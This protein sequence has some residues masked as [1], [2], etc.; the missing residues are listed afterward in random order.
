MADSV[1]IRGAQWVV[2]KALSPLSDGLVEAWAA[3]SALGPNI[4]AAKME[5]LYAQA[6]LNNARGR[7]IHNPA[8]TELLQKLRGLAYDAD[9][10]LD[11][12]DY[13]RIQ[14]ELEG[15]FETVD[16]GCFHDLVRDAHHTT[17]AAAKQLEC[18]SCCF[19]ASSKPK[20]GGGKQVLCGAWPGCVTDEEESCRCMRQ[21][22]NRAR[23]TVCSIGKRLLC[24]SVLPDDDDGSQHFN[25]PRDG[26]QSICGVC[27]CTC[28]A[29]WKKGPKTPKLDFDRV[30]ASRRMKHIAEQLQLIC[31][32]VSTI[33]D[34]ELLGSAIA[35]L[36]FIGSR[37]G[38]GGDTTTSRSTTT[39]KSIEPKLYGRD[40]EKN[41]I[42]ENITKGVHYHQDLSV[43]PIVGPGGIGKTTLT[44]YIY[45]SKEVQDHFQI[46]VWACVSLDFNVYRLSKEILNSIP[47]VEDEKG[48]SQIQSLDQLQKFIEKR[49]KQKRVLVVLDDIWK[50]SDEEWKRLLIPFT[51]CQVN[52]NIILVTT[53][54]FD[55]AEKVKT[56]NCKVTQLDGLNPTEFW[57]FFMACVFGHGESNQ[58]PKE[59]ELNS[60]GHQIVKKLK[61]SPL[62]A[63]TVGRLLR[64]NPTP[65]Y[66]TRV[67][68]S[69]EWDLQTSDYDIMPA[70]KLSYDYL[71]FHLQQCFS[72]C[73]LFPEDYK[74]SNEELIRFW[75][76]LD[77]L[78]PD[79]PS[80]RIEDIGHNYLNQLV[81]YE[82]FKKEIDEEHTY[83]AMHDLL[84][85]L[86]L[87]VS[88]Q[89][90][91]HID[92]S[93]GTPIEIPP[94]VYHLSIILSL[95]NCEE[96]TIEGSFK[97]KLAEMGSRLKTENLHTL[98]IFGQYDESFITIF[99][100]MFKDAKSLRVVHLSTMLHPVESILYSFPKL[101]HLR[102]IKLESNYM[103]GSHLPQSLSRFYHLRVLDIEQWHGA[104]SLP[105]D[106]TNLSKLRHFLV[107]YDDVH[108]NISNVGKFR[109]L[110]QLRLFKVKS[111]SDG[112]KLRELG[113]LAELGG[114]LSIC[115]LED[116][117][118]NIAHE[119]KLSYKKH[120]QKLSLNWMD[121]NR[122]TD[123][124]NQVLEILRPH[125]N[126]S[127]LQIKNGGSTCPTWLGTSL[128]IKGL[129]ALR[130]DGVHWK[131]LPPLGE[132]W[133]MD[134]SGH[135]YFG[136]TKVQNFRNLKKLK[137]IGLPN[138]RR[139]VA[140][141]V[142]PMFFLVVEELIVENC[143]ELIELPFSYYTQ[144]PSQGDEKITWFPNLRMTRI[145]DCPE[146]VSLPPVPFTQTLCNVDIA[147][148]GKS[149]NRLYY[150]SKSSELTIRGIKDLNGLNDKLLAFHSLTQ[151]QELEIKD[152]P[153]LA[154]SHLPML[155][156]LKKLKLYRSSIVV[157]L[158]ES[159]SDDEWQLPV[160]HLCIQDC[161]ASGKVLTQ[162]LSHLPML[163]ELHLWCC[164]NITRMCIAAEQ[165]QTN[166]QE[167][168]QVI[169]SESNQQQQV[170]EEG[171][172]VPSMDHQPQVAEDR[173]DEDGMLLLPSHLCNS[174]RELS[175]ERCTELL[176]DVARSAL[177]TSHS[178]EAG[179]W[180]LQPL[181]S[182]QRLEISG[183]PKLFSAYEAL[184][185]LFPSSLQYLQI[186]GRVEGVQT[187]DFSNLNF[188]TRL[189]ISGCGEDLRCEGV[190]PLLT[191]GQLSK[192]NVNGTPR[193]FAGLDSI[194]KGLQD[195]QEQQ[196]PLLQR[197]S[198]LQELVTKDFTGVLVKP[199]CR[200]LSS[201]L[202]SLYLH[203]NNEVEHFTKEQE[204][205]LQLL[206]SLQH[207]VFWCCEKLQR[208]PAGLRRLESLKT[209]QIERC[210]S[211]R[212]LPTG[213]LPGSLQELDVR[214]CG[215]E[216]L[217]QR[218][219][220]LIGTTSN[221]KLQWCCYVN[222]SWPLNT[223]VLAVYF[224]SSLLDISGV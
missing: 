114:S 18:T 80:K 175:L 76:G 142:C 37:S 10:V 146:L 166:D 3:S 205:A 209:L 199:I 20:H 21:L 128:S 83:Y 107:P 61:G 62:A 5:L 13:F 217:K 44:Q 152:C 58:M 137:L 77:I 141:E 1:A 160:E 28:M 36:E 118:V 206:T 90:C 223:L 67:L 176:L 72:Y 119:A 125:S 198:K 15:T 56:K 59:S 179:G 167:D 65:D 154:G 116:V 4:E 202:T 139:W 103:N 25:M 207:L 6:M 75:I 12:L 147:N 110:Q 126:L 136:C 113:E 215:N 91:L 70:L 43:L 169:E 212:S 165:Q 173:E 121:N 71:P 192:L 79:H 148:V 73:A 60:I 221:I 140:K 99:S 64:N 178:E 98:M 51:N 11:E 57:S 213:G 193:F 33:L 101:V 92:S 127:G 214:D 144:Q 134:G 26:K 69:K 143:K 38:T 187:L 54:F 164:G 222:S 82:F 66:W 45:N 145:E 172:A 189:I 218:C 162:L 190:W 50:C 2:S 93:S 186:L 177:P 200:L 86:A 14:D 151:L 47:K 34:L 23:R 211:I 180:G 35:K 158:L 108:S 29:P 85:A 138:F 184:A 49:L 159:R 63:K 183:C 220:K 208:L 105:R 55:V 195:E 124:E 32:K 204:E 224:W 30:N 182:L 9:D 170:A 171:G 133:L 74:F 53:R 156:S 40:P 106:M 196:Q 185:C 100:D 16:H 17:K 157:H 150:S 210:P 41:T 39:S 109:C 188:L 22:T 88:S 115:N 219:K 131:M 161:P 111:Q 129:K 153:S 132:L 163:S 122:N 46:R 203:S 168:T 89:E 149:L 7:E 104:C 174:L 117:Q 27:T 201:S 181:R 112:F 130:L 48:D 123:R 194:L 68:Q 81:N 8:L 24:S 87:K 102:Y 78:H 42:V 94:S 96:G 120:L 135:E 31:A 52:G 191:Q 216:K 19:S 97:K 84:H 95:K 197:S 155:T